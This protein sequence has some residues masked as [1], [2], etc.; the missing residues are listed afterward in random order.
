MTAPIQRRSMLR[1][2][3]VGDDVVADLVSHAVEP[4]VGET[5]NGAVTAPVEPLVGEAQADAAEDE[6]ESAPAAE[7]PPAA[8]LKPARAP[9]APRKAAVAS[10][11]AAELGL[12]A[13]DPAAMAVKAVT[14]AVAPAAPAAGEVQLFR[15]GPGRPRSRRRMEPFSSKLELGLRDD[16]DAYLAISGESIVDFL[17]RALRNEIAQSRFAADASEVDPGE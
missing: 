16:L 1:K 5:T 2:A 10:A 13:G 17:D 12:H 9:R 4:V 7:E 8:G 15:R 11:P 6:V 14:V 3:V